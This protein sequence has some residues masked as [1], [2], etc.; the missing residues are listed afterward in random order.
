MHRNKTSLIQNDVVLVSASERLP[1]RPSGYPRSLIVQKQDS[2][3][4]M[5]C[6]KAKPRIKNIGDAVYVSGRRGDWDVFMWILFE[7]ASRPEACPV[8]N[9]NFP[10]HFK[11][12]SLRDDAREMRLRVQAALASGRTVYATTRNLD[13]IVPFVSGNFSRIWTM[14][15]SIDALWIEHEQASKAGSA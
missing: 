5:I 7:G 8:R 1:I 4:D 9:S 3:C 13:A 11:R 12:F 10:D 15:R 6:R 2:G 14:P